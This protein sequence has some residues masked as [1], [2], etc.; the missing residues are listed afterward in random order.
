MPFCATLFAMRLSFKNLGILDHVDL[1]LGDLTVVCGRNNTG[2]TYAT[3]ALYGFLRHWRRLIRL[4]PDD[5]ITTLYSA[6]V[7][8]LDLEAEIIAPWQNIL[9][10]LGSGYREL[11]PAALA[12]DKGRFENTEVTLDLP[13]PHKQ[14]RAPFEQ[15]IRNKGEAPVLSFNK[16]ADSFR[17]KV[18]LL[19][20]QNG[21]PLSLPASAVAD[22]VNTTLQDLCLAPLIPA[23]FMASTERTGAAIFKNEL[24]FTQRRLIE[25]ITNLENTKQLSP[26]DLL[27]AIIPEFNSRYAFP[28]RDEVEFVN[29]VETLDADESPLL[30][31]NPGLLDTFHDLLGGE[32]KVVRRGPES[33]VYFVPSGTRGTRL[34]L[35]ESSSAVRSLL[36]VGFYLRHRARPGDLFMIDEPELNLHPANQRKIARLLARLVNAGL[37]VFITTHSDY[38]AKELNTLLLLGRAGPDYAK[39]HGYDAT[40]LLR[41]EQIALYVAATIKQKR[42]A[43]AA[44]ATSHDTLLRLAPLEDG[45]Y[46]FPSF[47]ETL[48]EMNRIQR[49]V[50]DHLNA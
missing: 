7:I 16:P 29:Q 34:G 42:D 15:V 12:A 28:V 21:A 11:L 45:A 38:I 44:R 9:R 37:K 27:S 20:G 50:W 18:T 17:L 19:D 46:E 32:Y 49:E 26:R 48:E 36:D 23:V 14:L 13:A 31:A 3:Y 4:L 47:D 35:G 6:G 8:E 39:K 33:G 25:A 40:E 2:K 30:Q 1:D 41:A 43:T 5:R 24:N 22:L 10:A